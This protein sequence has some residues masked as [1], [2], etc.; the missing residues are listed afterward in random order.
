[1][2]GKVDSKRGGTR[3]GAGRKKGSSVYGET[4]RAVRVPESMLPEVK[5]M[6]LLRVKVAEVFSLIL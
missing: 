1:M 5:T 4:T 3:S 2:L 6:S